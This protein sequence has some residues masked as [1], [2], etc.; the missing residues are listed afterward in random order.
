MRPSFAGLIAGLIAGLLAGLVLTGCAD[1]VVG[2]IADGGSTRFDDSG[3][4]ATQDSTGAGSDLGDASGG[5]V[6]SGTGSVSV[7]PDFVAVGFSEMI[8]VSFDDGRSWL[9]ID[10]PESPVEVSHQDIA[11][12]PDA[13]VVVGGA[14]TMVSLDGLSWSAYGD[15]LGYARA[16]AFGAGMFVGVGLDRLARSPDAVGWIDA[17]D[18]VR[19]FDLQAVA[20]GDGRFVAVGIDTLATSTDGRDW[21]FTPLDGPKLSAVAFGNG[22]FVAVGMGRIAV[23]VDGETLVHDALDELGYS[24]VCFFDGEFA[25][26][27][28]RV[29]RRSVDGTE[30]REFSIPDSGSMGCGPDSVVSADQE[31]IYRGDTLLTLD[32]VETVTT[33]VHAMQYTGL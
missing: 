33:P 19:D 18:G 31:R 16:V 3:T 25:A 29:V 20:F 28:Q 13:I 7:L 23:T 21:Q 14:S 4:D 24:H 9:E 30:W 17:R 10:E 15:E 8:A 12:S 26:L 27:S 1:E 32:P 5:G 2:Y 6:G 11:R 22:R